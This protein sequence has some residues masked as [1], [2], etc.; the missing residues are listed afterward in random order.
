MREI[1]DVVRTSCD[2]LC[3]SGIGRKGKAMSQIVTAV[4]DGYYGQ[5]QATGYRL[6]V[7]LLNMQLGKR[8]V[9][10]DL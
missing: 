6:Q 8:Y 2:I 4:F 10:Y 3:L 9:R 1:L 7:T 5:I